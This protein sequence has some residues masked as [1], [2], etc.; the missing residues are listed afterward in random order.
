ML[1]AHIHR[2]THFLLTFPNKKDVEVTLNEY[3]GGALQGDSSILNSKFLLND[4]HVVRQS[5]L[6]S[7][8]INWNAV[9][10]ESTQPTTTIDFLAGRSIL[11]TRL[12]YHGFD[13]YTPDLP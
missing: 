4:A 5:Q 11:V 9:P 13:L 2:V 1:I 3:Y 8:V 10:I 12:R 7:S 6:G